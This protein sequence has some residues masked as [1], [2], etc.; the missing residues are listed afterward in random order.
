MRVLM[1]ERLATIA[2]N[3]KIA[4][5]PFANSHCLADAETAA[6]PFTPDARM[7]DRIRERFYSM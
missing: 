2:Y 5:T 4:L 7:L 3:R 1:L 6:N